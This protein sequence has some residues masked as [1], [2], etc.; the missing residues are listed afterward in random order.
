MTELRDD[1]PIGPDPTF[2]PN[3]F[4]EDEEEQN[5]GVQEE[6][7]N[8][9]SRLFIKFFCLIRLEF[10]VSC[11]R[12]NIDNCPPIA[13]MS[14]RTSALTRQ[15][16]YLNGEGTSSGK[17]ETVEIED[18]DHVRPQNL[19][20]PTKSQNSTSFIGPLGD[21]CLTKVNVFV[22]L[23]IAGKSSNQN[24]KHAISPICCEV[25]VPALQS[26]KNAVAPSDI[27]FDRPSA[28][29]ILSYSTN[30]TATLQVS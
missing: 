9:C 23:L 1:F 16:S 29:T 19:L 20:R 2:N 24:Q 3:L 11:C 4:S 10:L 27:I 7:P 8:K 26:P 13:P 25:S 15:K 28:P 18:R 17:V 6:K 12:V 5:S 14:P 21:F 22:N 30:S